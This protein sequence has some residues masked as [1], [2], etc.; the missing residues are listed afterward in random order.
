MAGASFVFTVASACGEDSADDWP[1]GRPRI[2]ALTFEQQRSGDPYALDFGLRF[3]DTDGDL[4]PGRLRLRL[5]ERERSVLP[6]RD[7]FGAQTPPLAMDATD[8]HL[9]VLVRL[10]EREVQ[11]GDELRFAFVLEDAGG[12][13]SNEPW[14]VLRV[15]SSGGD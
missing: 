6:L 4:G 7:V 8:G 11:I 9:V 5:D 10:E 14:V 2:D 1:A 13:R 3:T 12:R 15:L